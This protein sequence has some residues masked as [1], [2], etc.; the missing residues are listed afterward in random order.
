MDLEPGA[1]C[2]MRR[3]RGAGTRCGPKPAAVVQQEPGIERVEH[4]PQPGYGRGPV[5]LRRR[6]APRCVGADVAPVRVMSR[7]PFRHAVPS[8]GHRTGSR[9]PADRAASRI[10]A[11]AGPDRACPARPVTTA[12]PIACSGTSPRR[13]ARRRATDRGLILHNIWTTVTPTERCTTH[14][15]LQSATARLRRNYQL[16]AIFWAIRAGC[17][18]YLGLL[19]RKVRVHPGEQS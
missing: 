17:R 14:R 10:P 15:T 18:H 1:G 8:P 2:L 9:S 6:A 11:C 4:R 16:E 13:G 12:L 19:L 7:A 5:N 3:L